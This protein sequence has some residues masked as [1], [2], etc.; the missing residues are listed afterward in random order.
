L[1]GPV[2]FG[3]DERGGSGG[4]ELREPSDLADDV[5]FAEG[6]AG[7]VLAEPGHVHADDAPAAGFVAAGFFP[8]VPAGVR[9]PHPAAG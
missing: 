2:E 4:V 8:G 5:G 1:G 7:G 3:F 6:E 9:L